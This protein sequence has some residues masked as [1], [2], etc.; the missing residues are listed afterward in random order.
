[1]EEIYSRRVSQTI[2]CSVSEKS[3][4]YGE[5][6]RGELYRRKEGGYYLLT[7]VKRNR[8]KTGKMR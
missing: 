5:E 3:L 8:N 7:R 4:K 6:K 1:M 2:P